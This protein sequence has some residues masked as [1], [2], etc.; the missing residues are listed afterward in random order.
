M[1]DDRRFPARPYLAASVA[2]FRD[3]RVL[4][5]ARGKPPWAG[6]FS[7][8]GG[9]VETGETLGEAALRELREEVGVEAEL[10]GLVAPVE[11]IEREA[12]G[13][14]KHHVVIA[15]HAARWVSG[16][17]QIGPEAKDIR[18]V[19]ER[20]MTGLPLTPG[21]AGILQQAFRLVRQ[22]GPG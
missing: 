9:L 7:L 12:D 10:I 16:E 20:D 22:D 21:L 14:V 1:T 19:T 6:V 2:V 15:A 17:P 8:P 13:R 4:L 3:G 5:A 18:W 11:V